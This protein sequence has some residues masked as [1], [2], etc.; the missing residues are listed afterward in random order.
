MKQ[1][2]YN[3]HTH[4]HPYAHTHICTY[5][6]QTVKTKDRENLGGSQR[7][8]KHINKSK[9][10]LSGAMQSE[11]NGVISLNAERKKVSTKIVSPVKIFL[12][13]KV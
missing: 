12:K 8:G 5:D 6:I 13:I 9:G 11:D 7:G 2:K 3:T 10:T 1:D 4:A